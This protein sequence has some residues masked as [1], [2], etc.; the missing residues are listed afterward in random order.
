[1][2]QSQPNV[3]EIFL[4]A[5]ELS[6][7]EE[8]AKYLNVVCGEDA[9]LRRRVERLLDAHPKVDEF[10]ESP[11]VDVA[12]TVAQPEIAERPGTIIG[13]Y[14]LL[15]QIGEGGFGVVFMAEQQEPVIRRV[16]L[17][18][19]KPGMDTKEVVAR[20]EA[21]R[22]AVAL[23]D[24]PNIANVL[25]AGATD[26]GRPYFIMELVKGIPIT[27]YCEQ[28]DLT[29]AERLD[30][31]TSVCQA[32]HHAHQKGVIHRDLK[33][34][35]I[36]VTLHDG[37]PVVKVIDFGV[38]K[39][40]NQ[41]L[42]ERTLFTKFAQIIGTPL[43]MSP[44]QA[45]MSGLDVDTRSDIYSL[46]VL[47]Y[48]LLTGSTPFDRERLQKVAIEE[49]RRIIR[50]EE[51]SKPSTKISTL[52]R[53]A[54][55]IAKHR[56][57][58]PKKLSALLHGDL[59]WIVMKAL[60]KDRTRRYETAKDFAADVIRH[61][62]HKAVEAGPPT[63]AYRFSKFMKRH[64]AAVA[65]AC[66]ILLSVVLGLLGTSSGLAYALYALGVAEEKTQEAIEAEN[67][68]RTQRER[69]EASE[70]IT[71][72]QR[73][74]SD[75]LRREAEWNLYVASMRRAQADWKSNQIA[76]LHLTLDRYVP[77][78]GQ[79]DLRGW[80]WYYL[81]SLCHTSEFTLRGHTDQ[82]EVVA[83][84]PNSRLLATGGQDNTIKIWDLT[85][86]N[87]LST[88]N[89]Q[90]DLVS[91]IDWSPDSTSLA[92][93]GKDKVV[94]IWNVT[95]GRMTCSLVG[96]TKDTRAVSWSP[97]G[98]LLASGSDD[99]SIKIWDPTTGD[100]LR[101][102]TGHQGGV[103]FVAWNSDGVRLAS[104]SDDKTVRVWD[105]DS[106]QEN[107][108][109]DSD[110]NVHALAWRPNSEQLTY[111]D[112][113]GASVRL[114]SP[115][116]GKNPFEIKIPGMGFQRLAWNPSGQQFVVGGANK[117]I[118][119]FDVR[120][121]IEQ[122]RINCHHR[123]LRAL[124]WSPDGRWIAVA[125]GETIRI[126][127][128]NRS[129]EHPIIPTRTAS[130]DNGLAWSPEGDLI[131]SAEKNDNSIGVWECVTGRSLH[132]LKGHTSDTL[133]VAW[134]PDGRHLASGSADK[135]VRIWE[136][137]TG[138]EIMCLHG[139]EDNVCSVEWSPDGKLLASGGNDEI[140]K[141]WDIASGQEVQTLRGMKSWIFSVSWSPDGRY[142]ATAPRGHLGPAS[143]L[144][145][146]ET[147]S[148]REVF[149][150]QQ[151]RFGGW[152]TGMVDW[153]PDGR[154]LASVGP[155]VSIQIWDA[156]N[157][158]ELAFIRGHTHRPHLAW[159]PDG[160]RLASGSFDNTV[161]IWA[162]DS[163][164]EVLLLDGSGP[165]IW[166]PDGRQ[167]GARAGGATQIWDASR[168]YEIASQP[169][170]YQEDRGY[171]LLEARD[172]DGA[173]GVFEKL[174]DD[175]PSKSDY[176]KPVGAAYFY[177]GKAA[178]EQGKYEEALSNLDQAVRLVP[179]YLQAHN[180]RSEICLENGKFLEAIP[181]LRQKY[182][183]EHGTG[184]AFTG[185]W[186]G[187]CYVV[188]ADLR[189]YHR[190]CQ[191]TEQEFSGTELP[192]NARCLAWTFALAEPN[193]DTNI[194][195]VLAALECAQHDD[196][197][198]LLILG[199]LLYRGDRHEE[200]VT[201]LTEVVR[202]SREGERA[203]G[204]TLALAQY[205]LAMSFFR[206]GN[207]EQATSSLQQAIAEAT[208]LLDKH[209]EQGTALKW[210][211]RLTL[212]L[213]RNEVGLLLQGKGSPIDDE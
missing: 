180:L 189:G 117:S 198:W 8:R 69:A 49:I 206:I 94:R 17:K 212:Q 58:D 155:D 38:A 67:A 178:W 76:R 26:S 128:S 188:T 174:V 72:E 138:C 31:F 45:E 158:K 157:G 194:S 86:G 152:I 115:G 52:G 73:L 165:V 80:E 56:K 121:G 42:T 190:I 48:E 132:K 3:D 147:S 68:E 195:S 61:V 35:N 126:W 54:T 135:T 10:M 85:T 179:E 125:G 139:H 146:W 133:C 103:T 89:G 39:A 186:L 171:R 62:E 43:Y 34:S 59:D 182:A 104:C 120:R 87:E 176:R 40:L 116:M 197:D 70:K 16:A 170:F 15:Q 181:S 134:S 151:S 91:S 177:K 192:D 203:S 145:V 64:R 162:Q 175:L 46:G 124:A 208:Q 12:A 148:W 100:E 53:S 110:G 27:D 201:R 205:F 183:I 6:S 21:E 7:T 92:V 5:L 111:V 184:K 169:G 149:T 2:S 185:L 193:E 163:H 127:D 211:Q 166:S 77:Q 108:A 23:M 143:Q 50:D 33:P 29:L 65:V 130:F 88:L 196:V 93:G 105:V 79:P 28:N 83:W 74:A 199:A 44:E 30:L 97:D 32:V 114:W 9:D 204:P 164:H 101:T 156:T 210:N 66:A 98:R 63:T 36:L 131:A 13:R 150:V 159:H 41:R 78:S 200:A 122:Y 96:H 20:F 160:S 123:M 57:T 99:G 173:I 82:V 202:L 142:L 18:V 4:A 14:K 154:R 136:S 51:P 209:E 25:D 191:L 213:L 75:R 24:H 84:S 144:R 1:M 129:W 95:D 140:V 137:D 22:Q 47:L 71:N 19:I 112:R 161:R 60:E 153:C 113:L 207:T 11:A 37:R 141:I 109:R 81:L 102:L 107:F 90:S 172:Y 167:L 55:V 119:I 168:G 118:S 106:G 187:L